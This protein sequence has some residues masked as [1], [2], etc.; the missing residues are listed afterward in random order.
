MIDDDSKLN[1]ISGIVAS[2]P[3]HNPQYNNMHSQ[4]QFT[5]TN[6]GSNNILFNDQT[7]GDPLND[8]SFET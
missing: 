6:A 5:T 2:F 3:H 4:F 7:L 8:F 1:N